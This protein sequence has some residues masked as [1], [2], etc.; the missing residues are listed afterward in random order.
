M[1]RHHIL[2]LVLIAFSMAMSALVSRTVF[3]RLPHLEDEVAYLFQAKT[4]ARGNLVVD[5]PEPRRAYWQPFVV[6]YLPTGERF[7]K[8]TPGWPVL[9]T[10]GVLLGQPWIINALLSGLTV[11]LTYRLGREIFNADVGVIAAVLTAFSPMALLLNGTLMGHTAALFGVTLFFYAY[12][13][14]EK[15]RYALR[16][17]IV[18]GAALGLIITTRPLT[19]IGI[20]APFIAWSLLRLALSII[21]SDDVGAQRDRREPTRTEALIGVRGESPLQ[22]FAPFFA[23]GMVTLIISASI[24]IY[25]YAATHEPTK[26][27]YTLVWPYDR[28][29][30]GAAN[31]YGRSGHTLQKGF[32]H[33]RFDLSLM[34]ADLYGWQ[35]GSITTTPFDSRTIIPEIQNQLLNEGDYWPFIGIS[36]ILLPFGL[37]VGLRRRSGFIMLWFLLGFIVIT[38]TLTLPPDLLQNSVFAWAWW[39]VAMAWLCFPLVIIALR[40]D[41]TRVRWTWLLA[42]AALG[43]IIA[44]FTYWIG[45]QRYSTRYYYEGLTALSIVSA[46][47]IVWLIQKTGRRWLIVGVLAV[48]LLYSL[49]GYSTPRISALYHFNF[50]GQDKIDAI[51][52]RRE[53]DQSVLVLV[54]GSDVRWRA[55]GALM[56]VTSPYLD[57]DIVVAWDNLQPGVRDA[58]LERFP[59]RQVI[60][61]EANGNDSWFKGEDNGS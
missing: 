54:S 29:G 16:W 9:L 11:A 25:N 60:E 15:R 22:I 45:S 4:Y 2:V 58:I 20:G 13:R 52:A 26:N 7:S 57:S 39:F 46:L 3:E 5:I 42:A 18:A 14:I 30:F 27:L 49:Y 19:A 33:V 41:E 17:G 34:A 55:T 51:E 40:R 28:V 21:R 43:L 23:L 47:P 53:G 56:S 59:D 10:V 50:V 37:I 35:L 8:Y 44:H 31:E 12:W 61:M 36:W 1:T 6:D 32:N 38:Q 48:A 24:P